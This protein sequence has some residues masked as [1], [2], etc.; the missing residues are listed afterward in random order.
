MRSLNIVSTEHVV[1][2]IP[3]V[4]RRRVKFGECDPAGVV[5]TVVF[6]EYV[7]SSAEL[8]YGSLFG[9]AP[10]RARDEIGFDTPTRALAFDFRSVLRPDD[11]FDV[12]VTVADIRTQ[13]YVLAMDARTLASVDV[14]HAKLTPVCI[15]RDVRR[16]I[17]IP[18][19]FRTELERYRAAASTV[20]TALV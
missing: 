19:A 17:K 2:D 12:T 9:M 11:E 18:L 16:A 8:F 15:A 10:Q 14:F 1:N 13:T 20:H 7:I 3:F 5:Y 4:V 6:C